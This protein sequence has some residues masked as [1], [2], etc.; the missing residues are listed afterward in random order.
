MQ[1]DNISRQIR[2][3]KPMKLELEGNISDVIQLTSQS[4][5]SDS[6]TDCSTSTRRTTATTGGQKC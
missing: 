2:T 6:G 3:W 5:R 4:S 1:N